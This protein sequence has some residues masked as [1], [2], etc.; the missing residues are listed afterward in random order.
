[1]RKQRSLSVDSNSSVEL[2]SASSFWESLDDGDLSTGLDSDSLHSDTDLLSSECEDSD[3]HQ[4]GDELSECDS[5]VPVVKKRPRL[6]IKEDAVS[7]RT[8]AHARGKKTGKGQRSGRM[9][10]D[11]DDDEEDST[12]IVGRGRRDGA[13]SGRRD[14]GGAGAGC[15]S[16]RHGGRARGRGS[17]T[18]RGSGGSR[19]SNGRGRSGAGGKRSR[20]TQGRS[21]KRQASGTAPVSITVK[22]TGFMPGEW[23]CPLRQPGVYIPQDAEISALSLFELFFDDESINR[24]VRS[25]LSYAENRKEQKKKRYN[26]FMRK[27]LIKEDVKAFSGCLILLGIHNVRNYRKAWSES[28]AQY[29]VRLHDLMTCQRFELIGAFLHIVTIE[30]EEAMKDDQ[31]RKIRPLYDHIKERCLDLYQPLQHLY[32]D[33]RMVK[34]KARSHFVQ[35]MKDKPVIWGF[36]YWVI[37]DVSGYTV[38]FDLYTGKSAETS[39]R[40]RVACDVVLKLLQPFCFQGYEV[41]VDNYYTSPTLFVELLSLGITATGTLRI[42]R[43][44]VPEKVINMKASL[45]GNRIPRGTGYYLRE[46]DSA[47]VYVCWRD[48]RCVTAMS[49]AYPGHTVGTVA[50]KEKVSAGKFQ[51]KAVACPVII[52]QYNKYMGGVDKSDQYLAYH[53]ILRRTVRYWKTPFYHLVDVAI[54]NAFILYN[55]MIHQAGLKPISENDFRDTLVLQIMFKYGRRRR[56]STPAGRPPRSDCRVKHGSILFPPAQKSRC[57]YC[58]LHGTTS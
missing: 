51:E 24:I 39:E 29:L 4:N 18:G 32:V 2:S 46:P 53:N 49:T 40:G 41:F 27:P 13:G 5:D 37:A 14:G 17:R 22:D 31:L 56:G 47:V 42:N 48:K 21:S 20:Q 43:R 19:R 44:G 11:D 8:R 34:S 25:T 33:E 50:R 26:L 23:F 45:Q 10:S 30:E 12:G 52:K 55:Y 57:Q 38:D 36:K 35:Y 6:D 54:V 7:S 58:K 28:R 9:S 3:V 16:G 1:M 15:G